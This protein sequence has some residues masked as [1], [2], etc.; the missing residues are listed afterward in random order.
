MNELYAHGGNV[1]R[2]AREEGIAPDRILDFSANINP[3]GLPPRAA[4]RLGRDAVDSRT[5]ACYP[6]PELTELRAAISDYVDV[7]PGCIAIGGGADSL[8]H[9]TVRALAPRR[10][11]I[12]I[13]AFC[14]YERA[15]RAFGCEPIPIALDSSIR[16]S[17]GD[18]IVLNNPH[19]PTGACASRASML[20]RVRMARDSGATVLVDEAFIDYAPDASVTR[21]AAAQE[22]VVA[23][24]SLTKFFGCPGLRVGYAAAS[25]QTIA[26]VRAQLPPWPVTTLASNALADALRDRDYRVQTLSQNERERSA[27]SKAF[28]SLGCHVPPSAANFLLVRMPSGISA[29]A[30][31]RRLL[32]E[33]AILVRQCDG[34]VG[35][36]AD[37]YLR[38]AVRSETENEQLIDAFGVILK[39]SLCLQT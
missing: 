37:R 20:D 33:Y 8:I 14:E 23:I 11:V 19:N 6:D 21:N 27:M 10:C 38:I 26:S 25:L 30:T 12:P 2:A 31:Y 39:N 28:Q 16:M 5:W 15:C 32:R 1:Q 18:L 35:I 3:M 29:S 24:R 9:A 17:A 22:S 34:F 7:E 4:E 36:E 13:P